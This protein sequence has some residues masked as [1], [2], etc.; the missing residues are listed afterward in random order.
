[1]LVISQWDPTEAKLRDGEASAQSSH[2]KK[3]LL[4]RHRGMEEHGM[5]GHLR[6]MMQDE[7]GATGINIGDL[8]AVGK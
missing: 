6:Q 4:Q 7:D 1:M 2:R 8:E 5:T 3:S